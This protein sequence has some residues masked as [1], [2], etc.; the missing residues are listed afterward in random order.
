[1]RGIGTGESD[2]CESRNFNYDGRIFKGI[3]NYDDGDLV[4][5]TRFYYHQTG[6]TVWGL[7]KGN[8]IRIGTLIAAVED[9]GSLVMTWQYLSSN[10]E[11][12][13][14]TC[15][16]KPEIL[17]DGRYRLHEEWNVHGP[18]GITGKSVIEEISA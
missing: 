1:M 10:N 17:P 15:F 11:F 13:S 14:G 5:D 2:Q 9:N 18:D 12:V 7:I 4:A 6:T 16:S 8:G 3:E